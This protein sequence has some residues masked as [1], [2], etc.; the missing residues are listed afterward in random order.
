MFITYTDHPPN[1]KKVKGH[2]GVIWFASGY[3]SVR[4]ICQLP[5]GK[6]ET[7]ILQEVVHLPGS[8]NVISQ[9]QIMDKDVKVEL[10]NHYGLNLYNQ[11]GKLSAT[12]PQVDGLFV[13]DRALE[14][15]AYPDINDSCLLA[16]TTTGY[17]SRHDAEKR[18]LWHCRL[19]HGGLKALEI[20][21][22][23]TDT[24]KMTAMCDCESC[25]KC[26]LA[27]KPFTLMIS[28]ATEP[29][30]LM[31]LDICGRLQTAIDE[32]QYM[33]LLIDDATRQRD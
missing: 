12:A 7:I 23:I 30:Q 4:L 6:T 14:L 32:V 2:N 29:L 5:D 20:L 28:R 17:A 25:I 16:L 8:F 11:H 33:L 26:K 10:V 31:H 24:P 27:R 13:P 19:A 21:P 1:T 22:K 9:S 15:T 3:G 18:M